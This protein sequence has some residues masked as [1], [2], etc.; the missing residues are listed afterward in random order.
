MKDFINRE[1]ETY[2]LGTTIESDYKVSIIFSY[3]GIGKSCFIEHFISNYLNN[4]AIIIKNDELDFKNNIEKYFFADKIC[5]TIINQTYNSFVLK[6]INEISNFKLKPSIS[7]TYN[8]FSLNLEINNKFNILQQIIIE[9][10]K[11]KN[12]KLIIYIDHVEKID[13]DSLIFIKHIL[14]EVPNI[15]LLLEFKLENNEKFPN[16]LV[17]FWE[18]NK[19][20]CMCIKLEKLS[21]EHMQ[22]VMENNNISNI[23]DLI[24][25]YDEFD[26]NLKELI[27][28]NNNTLES[29]PKLDKEE[30]FLLEFIN[31]TR[32]ELSYEE[33]SI[34]IHSY[35]L[36]NEFFFPLQAINNYIDELK[37]YGFVGFNSLKKVFITPIGK[38][39]LK[40]NNEYLISEMLINYYIPIISEDKSEFCLQGLKIILPLLTKN[41]DAR[42]K[43][44]LPFLHKN[45]VISR[46]NKE[47]IDEIYNDINFNSDNDDVRIELIK[48]YISFGDYKSAM[49]K[50]EHLMIDPDDTIRVLY[51]T[52][53]SHL[54][55]AD[56]SENK[57][58]EILSQVTNYKEKS[59]LFTCL[60][61]LYMKIKPSCEVLNYVKDLK[62]NNN[63]T[64]EDLNIINKNISIYY[65]FD[66]AKKML[67]DCILYFEN[68]DIKKLEIASKIT[69]STRLAQKGF[70]EKAHEQLNDILNIDNI[71]QLD[72]LYSTNNLFVINMLSENF[73]NIKVKD[74]INAYDYIQ[75]EYTKLLV[76]NNLL[77]YYCNINSYGEAEKYAKE[78]ESIGFD[79]YKFESY[80]LLTYLNLKYY[81]QKV[82][83]NK[84]Q[85][86]NEKLKTLLIKCNDKNKKEYINS[87]INCSKVSPENDFYF[88]SQFN[89]RPAFLGHWIIN[90]FDY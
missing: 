90:T 7:F 12:E 85:T 52:L 23:G 66:T 89:Y 49:E 30:E 5:E 39:F 67:N 6:L 20:K 8:W 47:I 4:T 41:A 2:K 38:K 29:C 10:L 24:G 53:I 32:G 45:I 46:C 59:A 43:T 22:T 1:N 25:N 17:K 55:P 13:Y 81:Y 84:I 86:Y 61:A 79:K 77:I 65:D 82:D 50:I 51:A 9:I 34:I 28:M 63:I 14:E 74:L 31:L 64:I 35:P 42:I 21:L 58:I 40:N 11:N 78:L 57:V 68:H 56:N 69:L 73:E 83:E 37:K 44:I 27:L 15:F 87:M 80:L 33:I 62:N 18:D 76:S 70:T 19:L 16:N 3:E 88:L 72:Y 75:D 54:L 71:S 26:G 36:S 48:L 60:V